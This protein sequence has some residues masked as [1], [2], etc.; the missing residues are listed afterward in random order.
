MAPA[1]DELELASLPVGGLGASTEGCTEG[2]GEGFRVATTAVMADT[3]T[4][5]LRSTCTLVAKLASSDDVTE[6]ENEAGE[7]ADV[8]LSAATTSNDAAHV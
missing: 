3:V 8:E 7:L 6:F 5:K 2:S 4:D 1:I